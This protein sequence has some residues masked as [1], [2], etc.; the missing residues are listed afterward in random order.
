MPC[1]RRFVSNETLFQHLVKLSQNSES[2]HNTT[3]GNAPVM[4][5]RF[6]M[7]GA[8]VMLAAKREKYLMDVAIP[9]LAGKIVT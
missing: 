4:A 2:S 6:A 7:E 5:K 1:C 9:N 8:S 3:G